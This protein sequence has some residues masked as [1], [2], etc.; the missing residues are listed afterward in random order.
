MPYLLSIELNRTCLSAMDMATKRVLCGTSKCSVKHINA[1]SN[2]L[3]Y[4]ELSPE[5]YYKLLQ[6][7]MPP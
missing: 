4:K 3:E 7:L 1:F 5:I 6:F 2:N